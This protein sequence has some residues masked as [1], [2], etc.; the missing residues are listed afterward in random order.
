MSDHLRRWGAIYALSL[1]ALACMWLFGYYEQQVALDEAS[2]HGQPYSPSE[3]WH[4][5]WSGVFENL[6]SEF[7]QLVV[8]AGLLLSPL[9]YVCW[10]ADQNADKQDVARIEAKLDRLLQG[11]E[12]PRDTP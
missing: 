6:Q 3:F 10:R 8:Q 1:A 9:A 12:R 2:T 5:Y 4:R 11:Q 7:W